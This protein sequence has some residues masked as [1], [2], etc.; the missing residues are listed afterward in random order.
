MLY[1]GLHFLFHAAICILCTNLLDSIC[2]SCRHSCSS[3]SALVLQIVLFCQLLLQ[4]FF[5]KLELICLYDRS[6]NVE[7]QCVK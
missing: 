1:T 4:F 6:S 7:G 2:C 3:C 5:K